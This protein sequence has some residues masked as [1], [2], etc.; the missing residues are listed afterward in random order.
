MSEWITGGLVLASV[1]GV[2]YRFGLP[3]A[4]S[5]Y[6]QARHKRYARTVGQDRSHATTGA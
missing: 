1:L 5:L 3:V 6:R 2:G 4:G